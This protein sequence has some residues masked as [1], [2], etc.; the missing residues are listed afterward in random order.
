MRDAVTTLINSYD[1]AGKYLDRNALDSLRSY[2]D[3]GTSRVQAAT[4]I[5]ANAAAIVKQAGSKLFEELPELIRPGGN[6]YTTRR[7]AACLR[8]MDYYLRYATYA[9]IAA[10]MNVLDE[11]VLQG[12]R[13]TYNSLDVPIGSTV[14]GIQIMKDLAKE[15]AIAAGVANATFVDEPFDY[16][17]RE[18]SEQNI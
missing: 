18:L 17:T 4:A 3:S 10:N 16:I 6:A 15:Q 2:F 8:D 1:L 11:R 12:L 9:L 5:N 13:E 7:Y 14:R